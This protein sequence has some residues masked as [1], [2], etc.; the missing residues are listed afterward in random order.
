MQHQNIFVFDIETI[1]DTEAVTNLIGCCDDSVDVLRKK[2]E[3]YHLEATGGSSGFLRPPFHK[4]VAISFLEARIDRTAGNEQY[5][6]KYL[7]TGGKEDSTEQDLLEGM[8]S[9]LERIKPRLI[10][11]NGRSFDVPVLKYRAMKYGIQADWFY[12]S[13]DKWNNYNSRYSMNWHCDLLDCLAD[14]GASTKIKLNEICSIL[15]FPGKFGIDGSNIVQMYDNGNIKQI[16]DYCETDVL[17]TYLLYLRFM[18]HRGDITT[19]GY[20][21]AIS[22]ILMMIDNERKRC[23]HLGEFYDAWKEACDG[24]FVLAK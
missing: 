15:G 2:L 16:R 21:K 5:Y 7:K 6:L 1:P 9:Y 14:F 18:H 22:D 20:N 12:N 24:I 17:N 8:F 10:S 13:G 3:E 23:P 4:V 19:S 11:F